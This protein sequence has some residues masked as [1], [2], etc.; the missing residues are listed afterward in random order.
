MD[1]VNICLV[2]DHRLFRKAMT[3]LLSTFPRV[4]TLTEAENGKQCL[5]LLS[6]TPD[7]HLLLLDI[8]MPV[9][10]GIDTAELVLKK[11]PD[12]KI[13]I[14]TM[15]DSESYME[16]LL[17]LGV[18]SFLFKSADPHELERAIS[19]IA[20]NG[21]FHTAP[22]QAMLKKITSNRPKRE[23]LLQQH[24]LTERERE[25][26]MLICNDVPVKE[27][28]E[29]LSISEKTV[30]SH[31]SA[32]RTKLNLKSTIAMVRW[33]YQTGLVSGF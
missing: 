29:R 16:Y 5:E 8:E 18:H 27:I 19:A 31:K 9:M 21:F 14:L 6:R 11:F 20:D 23:T 26:L 28:A 3:R 10:N 7:I 13:I 33:A 22:V 1:K 25:I 12:V 2:D 32:I 15:H 4:G 30:H 17:D 24:A